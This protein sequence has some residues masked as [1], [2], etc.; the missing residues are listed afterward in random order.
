MQTVYLN[1]DIAKFGA[2][3]NTNCSNIRDI[4]RLIECQTPGFRKYLI[5]ASEAGV[6]YEIKRGEDFLETPD[7]L[8][9]SLNDEPSCSS[10]NACIGEFD[11]DPLNSETKKLFKYS[12]QNTFTPPPSKPTPVLITTYIPASQPRP[13]V[14]ATEHTLPT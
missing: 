11:G 1:G 12:N 7:D 6:N 14:L 9:L 5:D 13:C 4:F 8:F 10:S 2:V 3:W